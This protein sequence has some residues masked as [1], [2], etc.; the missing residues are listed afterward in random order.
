M[1]SCLLHDLESACGEDPFSRKWVLTSSGTLARHIKHRMEKRIEASPS[2]TL[3]GLQIVSLSHFATEIHEKVEKK[4]SAYSLPLNDIILDAL[5]QKIPDSSSLARV[6]SIDSGFSL[7]L[8]TFRDLADAG[9]G[10]G[11][12]DFIR[13]AV[14][15]KGVS[16]REISILDLYFT[17][18]G[19]VEAQETVWAPLGQQTLS[20]WIGQASPEEVSSILSSEGG[21]A[22]ELFIHGFYDFTDNNLQLVAGLSRSQ[23]VRLYFP[24]NRMEKEI[25]P[26]FDFSGMVLEDIR[27]RVQMC[28]G[29]GQAQLEPPRENLSADY[30]D[31]TFPAGQVDEQP[32]FITF[33]KASSP[34]AEAISA[35]LQVRH[36][37][38]DQGIDPEDIMVVFTSA[39]GY[40]RPA[41]EAFDAFCL[42]INLV[43]CPVE[44]SEKSRKLAVLRNL[45]KEEAPAEWIFSFLRDNLDFCREFGIDCINFEGELRKVC[46][47][48]SSNWVEIRRIAGRETGT[49]RNLPQLTEAELALIDLIIETWVNKPEFP[50][51]P[52][53][54]C[55][56]L[57]RIALWGGEEKFFKA[58]MDSFRLWCRFQPEFEI[59]ESIFS[60][61]IFNSSVN[62]KTGSDVSLPG[63][64]LIP[65][66]R[67]RGLTCKALVLMGLSSGVFPRRAEEDYFLGDTT[68]AEVA[69][70]A[71]AL[72]HRLPLKSRLTDE[73]LLLFYLLNTSAEMIHWVVPETDGEGRLVAPTSW[74]QHFIHQW[75]ETQPRS[76]DRI[77]PSPIEQARF[78][79]D[80]D[81][82]EGSCLPPEFAFLLGSGFSGKLFDSEA[83]PDPWRTILFADETS[84]EFFG[85]VSSAAYGQQE[86]VLRVTSLE[87]L[88]KCPYMFFA[89]CLLGIAPLE[90]QVFPYSVNPM[91]Q[92]SLLHACL[93]KLF[94]NSEAIA[95]AFRRFL[96]HPEDVD[97]VAGEVIKDNPGSRLVPGTMRKALQNRIAS[98]ILEYLRYAAENTPEGWVFESLEQRM[99]KPFPKLPLVSVSGKADRIDRE[100]AKGNLKIIDYK[101]GYKNDLSKGG[102]NYSLNLGWK[103]Q[104]ALY[105]WMAEEHPDDIETGFSYIFLG[106]QDQKEIPAR[107]YVDGKELLESLRAILE[108]GTYLPVS[109]SFMEDLNRPSLEPCRYCRYM[110]MCRKIDPAQMRIA[111][112]LFRKI[113][114]DR[115]KVIAKVA[116]GDSA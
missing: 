79:K 102:K 111:A 71:G 105:G 95:P 26:A 74:I 60:A 90:E 93:E 14:R 13:D 75:K 115:A 104:A 108:Q 62:E 88:A 76:L 39:G 48:G 5:I 94:R 8:P 50:V 107:P 83:V 58:L 36:W 113:C 67:A 57:E 9:F 20:R 40:L 87:K 92:G 17:W 38:D 44:M 99:S 45:W 81:P 64:K 114:P 41:R 86:E 11:N 116:G 51:S 42:P 78:L 34:R 31:R 30:L 89:E 29:D 82:V 110:S 100:T 106:E 28:G 68:R 15:E 25:H 19:A 112:A 37:V 98:T 53:Q 73:M 4:N 80:L 66:M 54:A 7:L 65:M 46:F 91:E 49:R 52:E 35:A 96:Q 61:L 24:D 56:L 43:D 12:S 10:T 85:R 23:S 18:V 101:S 72:G 22:C 1:E 69:R 55:A 84:P 47:G 6:K 103:A 21:R 32:D 77:T 16:E 33:Q 3:G 97:S 70:R 27:A 2:L 109:N 63:V 59:T